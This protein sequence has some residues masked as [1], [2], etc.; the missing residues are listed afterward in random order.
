MDHPG[1]Q[2]LF[3]PEVGADHA[4]QMN[5]DKRID[6]VLEVRMYFLRQGPDLLELPDIIKRQD[7]SGEGHYREEGVEDK[8]G[9]LDID[10]MAALDHLDGYG[11]PESK[12]FSQ[13][14]LQPLCPWLAEL[15][16]PAADE[17]DTK[18]IA[19]QAMQVP[20]LV[21]E[22]MRDGRCLVFRDGDAFFLQLLLDEGNRISGTEYGRGQQNDQ[23]GRGDKERECP[24]PD[25][26]R[27]GVW[28]KERMRVHMALYMGFEDMKLINNI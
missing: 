18:P 16:K 28:F 11:R 2:T 1:D 21:V 10:I 9:R 12:G 22:L 26:D 4:D 7:K 8:I 14:D 17:E 6:D 5:K 3:M 20:E 23:D 25:P 24:V 15:D 13:P 27:P 19:D